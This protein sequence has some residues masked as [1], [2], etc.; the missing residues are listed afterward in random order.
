MTKKTAKCL[1]IRNKT[2]LDYFGVCL[3]K[4]NDVYWNKTIFPRSVK[5]IQF[6]SCLFNRHQFRQE[7]GQKKRQKRKRQQSTEASKKTKMTEQPTNS[8]ALELRSDGLD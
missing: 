7:E 6:I 5:F 1:E 2:E 4:N 3:V 8:D